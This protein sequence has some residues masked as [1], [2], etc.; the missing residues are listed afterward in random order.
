MTETP[1]AR[2][3]ETPCRNKD[4]SIVT[5][6]SSSQNRKKIII[7]YPRDL[8]RHKFYLYLIFFEFFVRQS[9][10]FVFFFSFLSILRKSNT[11]LVFLPPF[12]LFSRS[13][14]K[15]EKKCTINNK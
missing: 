14:K 6:L 11:I 8:G 7:I 4:F 9:N 5:D 2:V 10:I 1:V 3:T 15:Y 13:D 12:N